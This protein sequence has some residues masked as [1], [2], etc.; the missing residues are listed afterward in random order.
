MVEPIRQHFYWSPSWQRHWLK[1][2][3]CFGE[4]TWRIHWH[5]RWTTLQPHWKLDHHQGQH[6]FCDIGA[7]QKTA[8]KVGGRSESV[9]V[10][11]FDTGVVIAGAHLVWTFHLIWVTCVLTICSRLQPSE[12]TCSDAPKRERGG[13][14]LVS[15][16]RKW[17]TKC[18]SVKSDTHPGRL[19]FVVCTDS[20]NSSGVFGCVFFFLSADSIGSQ[21]TFQ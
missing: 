19:M 21:F 12:I 5:T 2:D 15:W 1:Q 4:G 8:L 20:Y 3:Q 18:K 17:V 13:F 6:F 14:G 9:G 11:S 7:M 16:N 10:S